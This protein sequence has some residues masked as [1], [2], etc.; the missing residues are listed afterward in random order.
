MRQRITSFAYA[1]RNMPPF[2]LKMPPS[3]C[4]FR[5]RFLRPVQ[6]AEH[7]RT[8]AQHV[9]HHLGKWPGGVW[10]RR[11]L[12]MR[13]ESAGRSRPQSASVIARQGS[14]RDSP[15]RRGREIPT[16]PFGQNEENSTFKPKKRE[17]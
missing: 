3:F 1:R 10:R 13:P 14:G 4:V 11:H 7:A 2:P 15:V 12:R 9:V 5:Q 16:H 8:L 17:A 6:A